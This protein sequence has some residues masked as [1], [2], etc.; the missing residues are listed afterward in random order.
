M[1]RS[2]RTSGTRCEPSVVAED[3]VRPWRS[4]ST[5]VPKSDL[6][7][8]AASDEKPFWPVIARLNAWN[9]LNDSG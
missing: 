6:G 3:V 1:Y 9:L 4:R 2:S 8:R 7:F 5:P